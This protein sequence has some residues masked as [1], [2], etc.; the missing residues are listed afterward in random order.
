[1]PDHELCFNTTVTKNATLMME[2]DVARRTGYNSLEIIYQ[3]VE[4][5]LLSGRSANQLREALHGLEIKGIGALINIERQGAD[6]EKL[7]KDAEHIMTVASQVSAKAIQIVTGPLD[8]RAVID[9]QNR[10]PVLGYRGLLGHDIKTQLLETRNNLR[11]LSD[12]ARDFGML[13]Y[14]ESLSWTPLNT[15]SLQQELLESTD[16]DNIKMVVDFWHC[17]TAGDTPETLSQVNAELIYGV[18]VCDSLTFS[19]GIADETVLRDVPTGEGVLNL[20]EWVG[21]VKATGYKGWWSSETFCK[22]L[23]CGNSYDVSSALK[24]QLETLLQ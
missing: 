3:K 10:A 13:L 4:D 1:M 14:L 18:H 21:A 19:G 11:L 6:K 17:Y 16:R 8:F 20:E 15:L 12:I 22:K 7:I 24:K 9:H 23:Q 2:L 5:Y